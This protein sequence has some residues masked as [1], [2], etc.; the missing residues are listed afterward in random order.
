MI[1]VHPIVERTVCTTKVSFVEIRAVEFPLVS[2]ARDRWWWR[3]PLSS[4]LNELTDNE[5]RRVGR[6]LRRRV[7]VV[8]VNFEPMFAHGNAVGVIRNR[9][10]GS[11]IHGGIVRQNPIEETVSSQSLAA[12]GYLFRRNLPGWIITYVEAGRVAKE[13]SARAIQQKPA[14]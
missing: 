6:V 3:I 14:L 11:N 4:E 1:S 10:V 12:N 9:R 5:R 8:C 13:L 7:Q 2:C